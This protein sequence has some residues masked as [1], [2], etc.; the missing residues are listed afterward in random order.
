MLSIIKNMYSKIGEFLF[1][2]GI[3]SGIAMFGMS[4]CYLTKEFYEYLKN[5]PIHKE[6]STTYTNLKTP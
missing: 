1:N 3:G 6:C 4:S 5:S 2:A